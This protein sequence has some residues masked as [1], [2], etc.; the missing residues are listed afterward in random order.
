MKSKILIRTDGNSQI[1]LGHLVRCTALAHMLKD[2]F[3]TN[4]ICKEIPFA[5]VAPLQGS[6]FGFSIIE[7]EDEFLRQLTSNTIAVLDGS[8]FNIDYQKK[9]KSSGSKL[10]CIDDLHNYE[11]VA[12]LIINHAP[13]IKPQ[14]YKTQPFTQFALGNEYALLRPSFLEQAKKE[15]KVEKNEIVLIC[16]GGSDFKN[17]TYSSLKVVLEYS[18]FKKIIIITGSAYQDLRSLNSL[19]LSDKRIEHHHAINEYQMLLLLGEA[20][21]VIVPAGGILLEAIALKCNVISGIYVDNQ[22]FVYTNYNQ[23]NCFIDACDFSESSLRAAIEQSFYFKAKGQNIIDG[24]SNKRLLKLF[25]QLKLKDKLELRQV[26]ESDLKITYRWATD[27]TIR[28]FSFQQHEITIEEHTNWFH[29]KMTNKNCIYLIAEM[30]NQL[31]GSIRFDIN[32]NE[33]L[34]S[35]LVSS[36]FHGQGLGQVLLTKGIEYLVNNRITA[37]IKKIIGLV[38]PTNIPS[39]KAFE[40]LGFNK[41]QENTNLKFEMKLL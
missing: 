37:T 32:Q 10:V 19:F 4:F 28:A 38:L 14:D 17:L 11:F 15:R 18:Q 1:G 27:K 13:G 23:T 20:E 26:I 30:D 31:I 16:F 29:K 33:A 25:L 41:F 6:G 12:D 40:R 35:Y 3:E 39:V 24:N 8:Q 2:D 36:E 9:V 22:K 7:K 34:I 21:L 5:M